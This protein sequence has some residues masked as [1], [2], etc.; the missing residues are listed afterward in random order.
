MIHVTIT[1]AKRNKLLDVHV[2]EFI[3]MKEEIFTE[4]FLTLMNS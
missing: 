3:V 2:K 1:M 4:R